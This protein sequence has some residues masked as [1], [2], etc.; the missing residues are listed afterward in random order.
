MIE[1]LLQPAWHWAL[2]LVAALLAGVFIWRIGRA[3]ICRTRLRRP[4]AP[5]GMG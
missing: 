4:P 5:P 1:R 2:L 3:P